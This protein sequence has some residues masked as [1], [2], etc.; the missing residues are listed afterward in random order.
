KKEITV[1]LLG[2][3][4]Y[5]KSSTGNT[6]LGAYRFEESNS[7]S[8]ISKTVVD[9]SNEDKNC[10]WRV[11]D[12]RGLMDVEKETPYEDFL[13][14]CEDI[15]KLM[16]ICKEHSSHITVFLLV[17]TFINK[18]SCE[19]KKSVEW[20]ETIFGK[21]FFENHCIIVL[22]REDCFDGNLDNWLQKQTGE[23]ANLV[24]RCKQRVVPVC[25]KD[26]D[27]NDKR[28]EDSRKKLR[29][30]II[31]FKQPTW[32]CYTFDDY[33]KQS[34]ER[35]LALVEL[36]LPILDVKYKQ[37]ISSVRETR[38][39]LKLKEEALNLHTRIGVLIEDIK[40]KD[41]KT[42]LLDKYIEE[43][44]FEKAAIPLKSCKIF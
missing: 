12:T 11:Y 41:N 42:G 16:Q 7:M 24:K 44:E 21:T 4:G 23:F 43:L 17:F 33:M 5:G 29:S 19:D 6:L 35:N 25:N 26:I 22:T 34:Q 18:F 10:R 40:R 32:L 14:I 2:K 38:L 37:E 36:E 13:S 31:E 20:I 9:Y 8:S 27:N 3:T 39:K 15:T 1:V 28:R 30:S